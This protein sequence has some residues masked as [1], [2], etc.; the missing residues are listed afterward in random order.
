MLDNLTPNEVRKLV[1]LPS[2]DGGDTIPTPSTG[3]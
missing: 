2:V 3:F 1:G